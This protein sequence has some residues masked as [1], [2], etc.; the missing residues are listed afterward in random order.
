MTVIE[1]NA[2]VSPAAGLFIWCTNCGAFGAAQI[3]NGYYWATLTNPDIGQSYQGGILAYVLQPGDPEY[4][5]NV[6][7]G[8][9]A[10]S[11]DQ[12]T[13]IPWGTYTETGATGTALGT[14]QANTTAI[15]ANQGAGSYAAQLCNDLVLN[16]Y[17]D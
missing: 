15:V 7:H 14:G 3:Y 6:P 16:G 13:G 9:I 12:S 2:I 5:P 4:D 1:R 8:L 11:S 10:A 17:N